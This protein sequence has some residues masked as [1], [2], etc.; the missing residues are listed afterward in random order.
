MNRQALEKYQVFIYVLAITLGLV[1]GL[2][3]PGIGAVMESALWPVLGFLLY[4]TFS[5][6]PLTKLREAFTD[7]RFLFAA[8]LGNFVAIPLAVGLLMTLAPNEPAVRLGLLMVL[9]VPCTDWFIVFT[10]LGGGDAKHAIAFSPISLLLQTA[11]LPVY[12]WLLLGADFAV[13]LAGSDIL[14]AFVGLILTPLGAAFLTEKWAERDRRG[15]ILLE[16]LAWLPIPLLAF[17]VF[18]IAASQ[19]NLVAG[20]VSLLGHLAILFTAY[21]VIAAI[22]ARAFA[23]AFRLPTEQGRTLAFSFGTRNSF[24]VLPLALALPPAFEIAVVVIVFQSLIELFGMTFYLWWIPKRLF[25]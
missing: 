11:L 19:V 5:Q 25:P 21:L 7:P 12:L 17:V 20:S 10:Q 23:G 13:T 3:L 18:I 22:L 1:I 9:L 16:R 14:A 24:V 2:F 15:L 4:A 8:V 6:V